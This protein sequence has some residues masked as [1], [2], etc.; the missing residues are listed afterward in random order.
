METNQQK[1]ALQVSVQEMELAGAAGRGVWVRWDSEGAGDGLSAYDV[2]LVLENGRVLQLAQ[3]LPAG[4][5]E[6]VS[7][8]AASGKARIQVVGIQTGN[9]GMMQG[10]G[11]WMELP[12]GAGAREAAQRRLSDGQAIRVTGAPSISSVQPGTLRAG[13]TVVMIQGANLPL[14]FGYAIT[15]P[16]GQPILGTGTGFPSGSS[17][18]VSLPLYVA[19]NVPPGQYLLRVTNQAGSTS[20]PIYIATALQ[21]PTISYLDPS[22]IYPDNSGPTRQLIVGGNNLPTSLSGFSVSSPQIGLSLAVPNPSSAILVL[23]NLLSVPSGRYTLTA[24]N[25]AGSASGNFDI[26]RFF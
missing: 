16:Y 26:V 3:G 22:I 1:S 25:A 2:N 12:D 19:S 11:P 24:S 4:V 7:G 13:T 17:N 21:A 10:L 9:G 23:S 8:A 5:H 20:V 14:S 18:S 15:N 6:L